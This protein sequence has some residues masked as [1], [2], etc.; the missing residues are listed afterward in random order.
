MTLSE[1]LSYDFKDASLLNLAL[2][3]RSYQNENAALAQGNNE[4]LEFLGDAVL[5]LVLSDLL[6]KRFPDLSEGDLSKVRASLVNEAV[7]ADLALEFGLNEELHLGRGEIISG[8][9]LKPRIL[10]SAIEALI[11]AYYVDAGFEQVFSWLEKLFA[12][13][14][15]GLDLNL[16]FASDYKT[17]LQE[18]SQEKH[19]AAPKY[20]V[21]HE[22]GPD[23]D[24]I[25]HVE[26]F[27]G[28]QPIGRGKGR[29]KKLAEQEAAR[30]G[31][32]KL[33]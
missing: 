30:M 2:T 1:K 29:S 28:D 13:R 6:M 21:I 23:H 3:H 11:G 27:L 8:G 32:E 12:E 24:K 19:R 5:D 20:K 25:F 15:D 22:E 7:L 33:V 10:A 16:H 31:L 18:L 9:F 26:V 14:L 17:R 4:R